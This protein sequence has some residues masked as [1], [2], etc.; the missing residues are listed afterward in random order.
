MIVILLCQYTHIRCFVNVHIRFHKI[1]IK[2]WFYQRWFSYSETSIQERKKDCEQEDVC[3]NENY[4]KDEISR[5]LRRDHGKYIKGDLTFTFIH[6][7]AQ[8]DS[9]SKNDTRQQYEFNK[10]VDILWTSATNT[11]EYKLQ[12]MNDMVREHAKM[13]EEIADELGYLM[14]DGI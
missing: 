4:F 7:Y 11:S 6:S 2:L 13:T 9:E 8:L 1:N 14:V 12:A 3:R 10:N 5:I